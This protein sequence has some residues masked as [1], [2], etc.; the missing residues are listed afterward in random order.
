MHAMPF[1]C[2]KPKTLDDQLYS[3]IDAFC[4]YLIHD[5]ASN[6][7]LLDFMTQL[8]IF[9]YQRKFIKKSISL[10]Y[11]YQHLNIYFKK[12][13]MYVHKKD[14]IIYETLPYSSMYLLGVKL[15]KFS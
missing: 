7:T 2:I 9:M 6:I 3:H 4:N 13:Y 12:H 15:R 10:D 8:N 1:L 11:L 14:L 5:D